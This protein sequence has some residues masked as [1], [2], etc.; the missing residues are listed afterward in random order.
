M[1]D[2]YSNRRAFVSYI[3]TWSWI[4]LASPALPYYCFVFWIFTFQRLK[5]SVFSLARAFISYV[6]FQTLEKISVCKDFLWINA[7]HSSLYED[8]LFHKK[9]DNA[10]SLLWFSFN[11][12]LEGGM[13]EYKVEQNPFKHGIYRVK[14][15]NVVGVFPVIWHVRG[16]FT[17]FND[18]NCI[19][20]HEFFNLIML[21]SNRWPNK[22]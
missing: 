4:I 9:I 8:L 17:F 7:V 6:R 14:S 1:N 11:V 16:L 18:N 15:T 3:C 2:I 12:K 22:N 10:H 5:K 20:L 21:I 19:I 13:C